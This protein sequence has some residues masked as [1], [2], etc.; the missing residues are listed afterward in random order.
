MRAAIRR[1]ARLVK[2][3]YPKRTF[4]STTPLCLLGKADKMGKRDKKKIAP[5]FSIK[6]KQLPSVAGELRTIESCKFK[7]RIL[8]E[9]LDFNHGRFGWKRL[10]PN[11]ILISIIPKL[12]SYE[13][14]TWEEA[15]KRKHF[16]PWKT[17]KLDAPL[18][19]LAENR[20]YEDLYQIDIDESSRIFGIKNAEVFYCIWYDSSHD[21]KKMS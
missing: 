5:F 2:T 15:S 10:R 6:E 8:E 20:G 4:S 11:E 12:H 21:G 18:K 9:Y 1:P 14:L 3:K 13:D 19:S 17:S 16:H 7:W